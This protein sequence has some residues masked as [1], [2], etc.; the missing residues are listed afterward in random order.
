MHSID[1]IISRVYTEE[2]KDRLLHFDIWADGH[3]TNQKTEM[4]SEELKSM[5]SQIDA[6]EV[7]I[8][9][10]WKY[11]NQRPRF[12]EEM[13]I[14]KSTMNGV[15]TLKEPV[16]E[17]KTATTTHQQNSGNMNNGQMTMMD[18]NNPLSWMLQEKTEQLKEFKEKYREA[19]DKIET[20]RNKKEELER[21]L[22]QKDHEIENLAD[23]VDGGKGLNGVLKNPDAIESLGG[24][25]E[26][27]AMAIAGA[28]S[29]SSTTHNNVVVQDVADW[30]EDISA[31]D[32]AY[33]HQLLKIIARGHHADPTFLQMIL[34]QFQ[35][36]VQ[37][38][39]AQ[40]GT[41]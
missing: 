39:I 24:M 35:S 20:L 16:S 18:P 19:K 27:I 8:R 3:Q 26:K 36:Q 4:T 28:K 13:N 6:D 14:E 34:T 40:N 25:A 15:E 5:L 37:S 33:F 11:G 22:I 41:N 38:N 29:N 32:Q 17:P 1:Y 23:E 30:V 7:K 31:E 21:T 9:M 12:M 2:Q 10:Y